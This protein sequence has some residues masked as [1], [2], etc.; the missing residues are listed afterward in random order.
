MSKMDLLGKQCDEGGRSVRDVDF[1]ALTRLDW[2][3]EELLSELRYVPP[4]YIELGQR[5]TVGS[6][7]P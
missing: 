2:I 1:K 7:E 3:S 6:D 5:V 4:G